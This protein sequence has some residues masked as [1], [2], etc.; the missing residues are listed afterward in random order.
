MQAFEKTHQSSSEP[1]AVQAFEFDSRMFVCKNVR[2]LRP[3]AEEAVLKIDVTATM[4]GHGRTASSSF[5]RLWTAEAALS[6]VALVINSACLVR[7][8]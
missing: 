5:Q 8:I 7:L 2:V 6:N 4:A 3:E 1:L